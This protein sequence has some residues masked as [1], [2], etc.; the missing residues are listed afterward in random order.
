MKK[1]RLG[2][3]DLE[4]TVIGLG[5]WAHGG[6]GWRFS[7]GPQDDRD[8]IATIHRALDMGVNWVDTAAV[9]GL[10]HAEEVLGQALRERRERPI[11]ATK[12]GLV[13]DETRRIANCLT[14]ASVLREAEASLR[15]LAIDAI[16][17]YQIHWPTPDEQI[18][19][20][21][22]AIDMLR[23]QGKVRYA[24]VSNF[25]VDHLRRVGARAR[26]ASLQPPYS[27]LK[28]EVEKETLA[29]CASQKI[30][31]VVYSPLQK[32]LLTG[33]I[34][35][36]RV[37][38]LAADDHR[39]SDPNFQQ[40]RLAVNLRF[41]DGLRSVASR[42]DR[43]IAQL[44]IAWTLRRPEV[45]SAIVGARRPE[46]LEETL[47]AADWQL[48]RLELAQIERLHTQREQVLRAN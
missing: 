46:Q 43:S 3:T 44:A 36:A 2:W 12:C 22:E 19:E 34:T 48:D 27:L 26:V 24:G 39:R 42:R 8:S 33:R 38:A 16:D 37:D 31:V 11:V 25:G 13:W 17:L 35:S 6:S 40:P 7:W 45:T 5:T 10:G 28:R 47:A 21:W 1:R 4:L 9:Y 41:V 14:R 15:R 20:A 30:G 32:G 29:C 18:E 23:A